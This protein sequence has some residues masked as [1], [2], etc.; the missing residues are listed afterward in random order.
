MEQ[1]PECAGGSGGQEMRKKK[2][3][4]SFTVVPLYVFTIVFVVGPLL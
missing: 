1:R 3:L 2:D 4:W